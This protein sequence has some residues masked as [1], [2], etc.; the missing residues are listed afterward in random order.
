M[1]KEMKQVT[2]EKAPKD[3]VFPLLYY[4]TSNLPTRIWFED[5]WL[6]VKNI[7]MDKGIRVVDGIAEC[8]TGNEVK[9]D[10]RIVIGEE[11]IV[12]D[13][14]SQKMQSVSDFGFMTNEVST[15]RAKSVIIANIAHEMKRVKC[16]G[17]RVLLVGGPAI[18]HTGAAPFVARL[19]RDGYIHVLF[20]GN[21]LATHD[22]EQASLGTSLGVRL[23]DGAL[24]EKGYH[25]H[26][27]TINRIRFYGSIEK[28]VAMDFITNGIMYEATKKHI[29]YVLAGSIRDDGPLPEVITDTQV[30]QKKMR[31]EVRKGIDLALMVATTLHTVAV[32]NMLP[33]SVRKVVVD[34]NALSVIKLSDRG[35]TGSV[36]LVTDCEF[37]FSQLV[38]NLIE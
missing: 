10:D 33:A 3:G 34:A 21:A 6:D 22:M 19:I 1:E 16:D 26:L 18:V 4:T 9:K 7:E 11:G 20:S 25:H 23:I 12:V 29:P 31:E 2:L 5:Q 27:R 37:F 28:A 24:M 30:A 36:G 14:N 38:K 8:I 35:T 17:G 32:G 15:E 13:E